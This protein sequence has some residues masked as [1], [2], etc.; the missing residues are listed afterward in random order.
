MFTSLKLQI[1][2]V[3]IV[4]VTFETSPR[5]SV[6]TR[7]GDPLL[8]TLPRVSYKAGFRK[9]DHLIDLKKM[10]LCILER[11]FSLRTPNLL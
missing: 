10:T 5:K 7:N 4:H 2:S 3:M 8:A 11:S 1:L 9:K 6:Y